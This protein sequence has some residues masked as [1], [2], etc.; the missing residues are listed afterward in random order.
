MY[1]T[2]SNPWEVLETDFPANGSEA[3]QLHFLLNYAVLAPSRHNSQPW[4]FRVEHTTVELYA[5]R[6]RRLPAVDSDDRELIISCGAAL[7]NLLIAMRYFGYAPG[8]D[9]RPYPHDPDLLARVRFNKGTEATREER[10]LFHAIQ[11]RRTNRHLF[12]EREVPASLIFAIEGIAIQQGTSFQVVPEEMRPAVMNLIVT[13][14]RQLWSD[15][16]YRQE[17]AAWTRPGRGDRRDGVPEDALGK[18]DLAASLN[19][20]LIRSLILHDETAKHQRVASGSTVLAVISTYAD[21]WFDWLAAGQALE[22]MLLLARSEEVWAS[23][24]NQP[25]EVPALRKELRDILERKDF[26][27]MVLRMGYGPEVPPT[28]RRAVEEVLLQ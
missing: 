1:G 16:H 12:E 9:I 5:D 14:D 24:F 20:P 6:S 22:K 10:K 18:E 8:I 21:S 4:R 11:K 15:S 17:L 25:I 27:Q 13:A 2:N 19:P 7:E 26:P 28:P 3:S 23:F